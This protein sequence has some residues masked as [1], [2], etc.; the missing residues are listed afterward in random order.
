MDDGRWAND[1]RCNVVCRLSSI[2]H[3]MSTSLHGRWVQPIIS[4]GYSFYNISCN[5]GSTNNRGLERNRQDAKNAKKTPR[6]ILLKCFLSS[7]FS[8]SFILLSWRFLGAL[9]VLA[10]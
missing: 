5:S 7:C 6:F 1:G 8:S 3:L 10:V 2:V 9:G 4:Q